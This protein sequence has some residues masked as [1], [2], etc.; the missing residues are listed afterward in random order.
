MRSATSRA[1]GAQHGCG[2]ALLQATR[3][4]PSPNAHRRQ[5]IRRGGL[6]HR[7]RRHYA[8]RTHRRTP[9]TYRAAG[10]LRRLPSAATSRGT[11][12]LLRGRHRTT[13][14]ADRDG[15]TNTR[16]VRR[17]WAH[18]HRRHCL[19]FRRGRHRGLRDRN[20]QS[21]TRRH[22]PRK[23]RGTRGVRGTRIANYSRR[24]GRIYRQNTSRTVTRETCS[25]RCGLRP[26][27]N[28]RLQQ[29]RRHART[30]LAHP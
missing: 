8:H 6:L 26:R 10:R 4:H 29:S 25:S 28:P 22:H 30:R 14:T 12:R 17:T 1:T 13:R 15:N 11:A 18:K 16:A 9:T 24:R 5:R 19:A 2:A 27:K 20:S 21:T 23:T 7:Y 3:R